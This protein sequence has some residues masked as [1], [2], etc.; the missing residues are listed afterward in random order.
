MAAYFI[1]QDREGRTVCSHRADGSSVLEHD[2]AH[3]W[4][5]DDRQSAATAARHLAIHD[6]LA[7]HAVERRHP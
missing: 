5:F 2:E 1:L 6:R 4:T 7:V 3:A